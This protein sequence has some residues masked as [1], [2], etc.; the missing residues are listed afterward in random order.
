MATWNAADLARVSDPDEVRIAGRRPDGSL[1]SERIIWA[2]QVGDEL[3]VRS[4]N[5]PQAAWFRG[6]RATHTGRITA[7]AVGVDVQFS[8][9]GAGDPVQDRLD[10][11][12]RDKYGRRYPGPTESVT[13]ATARSATLKVVPAQ[14][15]P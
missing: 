5:G 9:V 15:E 11:A 7:G 3:Y 1:R 12:Y 6:T 10:T 8:D 2:V 4:V 14:P 13:G